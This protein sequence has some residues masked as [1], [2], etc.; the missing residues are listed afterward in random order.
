MTVTYLDCTQSSSSYTHGGRSEEARSIERALPWRQQRLAEVLAYVAP[1]RQLLREIEEVF[2]DCSTPNWDGYGA[3]PVDVMTYATAV[4][5]LMLL[6]MGIPAPEISVDPDGDIAFEWSRDR[7][8][9]FS[10]SV[11]SQRMLVYAARFGWATTH[12]TE[13][14][15]G[16]I[17]LA[18]RMNL[19]RI[20][21]PQGR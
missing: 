10:V 7:D 20:S 2:A 16:E 3:D 21:A 1:Q 8:T 12:G 14:F 15:E 4:E 9:I 17:P 11:G 18:I 19:Y 6:P 5:F 13:P